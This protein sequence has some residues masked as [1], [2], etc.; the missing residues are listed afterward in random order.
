MVSG[1]PTAWLATIS[2]AAALGSA[3]SKPPVDLAKSLQVTD[4]T[5]G[6][7][8]AGVVEGNKNKLVPS[9]SFRLKNA[10]EPIEGTV[11][12][13]AVFKRIG[14]NEELGSSFVRAVDAN[15][16]PSG[17]STEPIVLRSTFGYTGT[18]PRSQ[19][20]QNRLFVDAQVK[21][22]AKYGSS[23]WTQLGEYKVPRVLLTK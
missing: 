3:C 12:L 4:L 23:Q 22:F 10:G 11:Q 19:L 18:D 20:L 7:Y 8:D 2:L 9:I 14:D 5:A 17:A 21:L 15:G 1:I 16:L 6:W 13:N